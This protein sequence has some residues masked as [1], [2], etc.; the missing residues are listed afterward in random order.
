MQR[1]VSTRPLARPP[2]RLPISALCCNAPSVRLSAM[3]A[4]FLMAT[5]E[6][7]S[8]FSAEMTTPYAPACQ[9]TRKRRG[10]GLVARMR[11]SPCD[12]PHGSR[13]QC[14]SNTPQH[15]RQL[16][17]ADAPWPSTL[18]GSYLRSTWVWRRKMG[19]RKNVKQQ[20]ANVTSML[21][22]REEL[23][24]AHARAAS[25]RPH[26]LN[27]V[28][29]FSLFLLEPVSCDISN[30]YT[31]LG[32]RAILCR[33]RPTAAEREFRPDERVRDR[34]SCGQCARETPC[35]STK[36]ERG[37]IHAQAQQKRRGLGLAGGEKERAGS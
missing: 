8:L 35:A 30:S 29:T 31:S 2:A 33:R 34:L 9:Q 20:G 24:A 19:R 25:M 28:V 7:V 16:F 13:R 26:T 10:R 3:G 22:R 4:I 15:V 32:S 1:A 14:Q 23:Q 11:R 6:F 17:T 36:K 18:I 37:T 27:F 5:L 21:R 12:V